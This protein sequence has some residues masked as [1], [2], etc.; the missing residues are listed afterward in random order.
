MAAATYHKGTTA[1]VMGSS[2]NWC[3]SSSSGSSN[4][5]DSRFV[6]LIMGVT[7]GKGIPGQVDLTFSV[8]CSMMKGH[9]STEGGMPSGEGSVAFL[10][11][12]AVTTHVPTVL[13]RIKG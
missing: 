1:A 9:T 8:G 11:R 6:L 7:V 4:I 2:S 5:V 12:P 13:R 10:V 3:S